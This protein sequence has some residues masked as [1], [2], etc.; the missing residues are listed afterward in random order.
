MTDGKGGGRPA[1]GGT[2]ANLVTSSCRTE[3]PAEVNL[4]S[5][6][7]FNP[8]KGGKLS[9]TYTIPKFEHC[10]LATPLI[11]LVIPGEGN[12]VTLTLGQA[13]QPPT[14]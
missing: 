4:A 7:G 14:P 6:T 2:S 5:E 8:I 3:V 9:G 13:T 11:N 1:P 12:T 10:L